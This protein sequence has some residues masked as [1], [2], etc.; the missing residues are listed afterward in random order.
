MKFSLVHL[1]LNMMTIS[2]IVECRKFKIRTLPDN[3]RPLFSTHGFNRYVGVFGVRIVAHETTCN[4]NLQFAANLMAQILDSD[5]D[6]TPDDIA[7]TEQLR[8]HKATLLIVKDDG[9]FALLDDTKII[10]DL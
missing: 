2:S 3:M 4:K 10:G 6:G 8:K 1:F 5:S 9:E 7:V